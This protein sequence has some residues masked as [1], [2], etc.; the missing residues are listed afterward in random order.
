MYEGLSR[1]AAFLTL[2]FNALYVAFFSSCYALHALFVFPFWLLGNRWQRHL[3]S[4]E[5]R[6]QGKKDIFSTLPGNNNKSGLL[7]QELVLVT[8]RGWLLYVRI[9][10]VMVKRLGRQELV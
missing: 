5:L 6:E 1:Q 2:N 10:L 4:Q 3:F 7:W 9:V 8:M